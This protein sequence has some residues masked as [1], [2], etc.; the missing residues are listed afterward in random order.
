MGTFL[1][2]PLPT[3]ISLNDSRVERV[4]TASVKIFISK[5]RGQRRGIITREIIDIQYSKRDIMASYYNAT[6]RCAVIS[7]NND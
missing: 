4:V 6:Y 1:R 3:S 7:F 5:S 2:S